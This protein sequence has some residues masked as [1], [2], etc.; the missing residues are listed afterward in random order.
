[1]LNNKFLT[2]CQKEWIEM[3]KEAR[4]LLGHGIITAFRQ[5]PYLLGLF[6]PLPSRNL[7]PQQYGSLGIFLSVMQHLL[8]LRQLERH[9]SI[10]IRQR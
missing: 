6:I 8:H 7:G 5:Q 9:R 4:A 3:V 1:M 10:K 2:F